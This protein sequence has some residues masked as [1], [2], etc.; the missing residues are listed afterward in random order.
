MGTLRGEAGDNNTAQVL[1]NMGATAWADPENQ[2][3][4]PSYVLA[5][6]SPGAWDGEKV[7]ALVKEII[8]THPDIDTTRVYVSRFAQWAALHMEHNICRS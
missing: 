6:Q 7:V 1:A 2:A 5:P 3:E 4:N 8:S